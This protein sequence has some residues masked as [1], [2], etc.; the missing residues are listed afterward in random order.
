MGL[1][2]DPAQSEIMMDGAYTAAQT[3]SSGLSAAG[4]SFPSLI[5]E[6]F[7]EGPNPLSTKQIL[8]QLN[9]FL[10]K[11]D[12]TDK[13]RIVTPA[14]WRKV[15]R[16][17]LGLVVRSV[18]VFDDKGLRT[19][20]AIRDDAAS[21]I[22]IKPKALSSWERHLDA[23]I[24]DDQIF[25][26]SINFKHDSLEGM[27]LEH[28]ELGLK[29]R[30]QLLAKDV[31]RASHIDPSMGLTGDTNLQWGI[32]TVSAL[33]EANKKVK[34]AIEFLLSIKKTNKNAACRGIALIIRHSYLSKRRKPKDALF[35]RWSEAEIRSLI[36]AVMLSDIWEIMGHR[37]LR[38]H[39]EEEPEINRFLNE[40]IFSANYAKAMND[41][42]KI[43]VTNITEEEFWSA[44]EQTEVA[45]IIFSNALARMSQNN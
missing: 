26:E 4:I 30:I 28:M 14:K 29:R 11:N 2:G 5:I 21:I 13:R 6:Q 44:L 39:F 35:D 25:E 43:D 8:K 15:L 45:E 32:A 19:M 20:S 17:A 40:A 18:P 9:D 33:E 22:G 12:Y 1:E 23:D 36:T 27:I 7:Q 16:K 38:K 24:I 10:F 31:V 3:L 41:L 34:A 37:A 42:N